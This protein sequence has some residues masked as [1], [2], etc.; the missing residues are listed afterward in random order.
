[1]HNDFTLFTR[2]VPSG[3][4]VVY[5]YVYDDEGQRLG[6]WTTGRSNKT[7]ARNYCNALNRQGKLLP[8]P[9]EMPTF[10]EF[11]ADFWDW[12]NSAYLRDRKKRRKLTQAYADKNKR[13]INTTIIPYFGKMRLDKISG[14]VIDQWLDVMIKDE[15]RNSTTNG[16]FGTL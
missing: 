11:S 16:Y 10:S 4:S 6:P 7:A 9:Q 2:I 14:E 13:V 15:Y 3:K 8:S 1:M 5:Y 12:E